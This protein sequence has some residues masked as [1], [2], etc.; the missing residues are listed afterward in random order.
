MHIGYDL[1]S[2]ITSKMGLS[3]MSVFLRGRNLLTFSDLPANI[4]PEKEG[5]N[6]YYHPQIRT[7]TL[8]AQIAF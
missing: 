2:N 8:G 3:K 5:T 6:S 1:P 7:Y 4:D